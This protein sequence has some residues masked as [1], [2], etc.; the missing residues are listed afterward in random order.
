[1]PNQSNYSAKYKTTV[2]S[3]SS[4]LKAVCPLAKCHPK[5]AKNGPG[6]R[7]KNKPDLKRF[8]VLSKF[9]KQPKTPA[10]TSENYPAP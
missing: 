10:T 6:N 1:M 2:E 7:P 9:R 8:Y 3:K 4:N 5:S